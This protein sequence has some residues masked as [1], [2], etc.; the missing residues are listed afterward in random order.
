MSPPSGKHNS[1]KDISGDD[2]YDSEVV[3]RMDG[4]IDIVSESSA[5]KIKKLEK[6]P[7]RQKRNRGGSRSGCR[8]VSKRHRSASSATRDL[9]IK[10]NDNRRYQPMIPINNHP[11]RVMMNPFIQ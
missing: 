5:F 11:Q 4:T 1:T 3:Q 8:S 6:C 2:N 9:K 10:T 7:S